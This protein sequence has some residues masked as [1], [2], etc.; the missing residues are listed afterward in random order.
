MNG[1]ETMKAI[2]KTD[3]Q[4]PSAV[5]AVIEDTASGSMIL[6]LLE[7]ERGHVFR[8]KT[9]SRQKEVRLHWGVN[10]IA[11]II[12][13]GQVFLPRERAWARKLVDEAAQFP[14]GQHDDLVDMLVQ[15]IEHLMPRAWIAENRARRAAR[16]MPPQNLQ[17]AMSREL[18]EKIHARMKELRERAKREAETGCS[19]PGL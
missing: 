9:K 10:S 17:E 13:R 14:H 6:D 16:A 8:G 7:R 3:E 5:W 1:P 2:R 15:G 18:H 19:F 12:E 4:W 11:A